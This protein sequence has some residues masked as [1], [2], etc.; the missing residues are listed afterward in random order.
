M[1][2]ENKNFKPLN[3]V[4][5]V[6]ISYFVFI[7]YSSII[8]HF[9]FQYFIKNLTVGLRETRKINKNN[10]LVITFGTL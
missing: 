9:A 7:F 4:V 8:K 1:K 10:Q 3:E 5:S 2:F 6:L